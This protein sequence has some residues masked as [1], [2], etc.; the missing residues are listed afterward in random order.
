MTGSRSGTPYRILFVCTGNTCRSPMAEVIARDLIRSRGM[1]HVTVESA[2]IAAS[3]GEGATPGAVHAAGENGLDLTSHL[4]RVL[5][6]EILGAVDLILGMTPSHVSAVEAAGGRSNAQLLSDFVAPGS[7][8]A[9]VG[10]L[11][12][13]GGGPELYVATFEALERLIDAALDRIIDVGEP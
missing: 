11:D 10:V 6:A 8:A 5:T 12:P 4:S 13:F 9:Q 3:P 1:E 7:E 2:G